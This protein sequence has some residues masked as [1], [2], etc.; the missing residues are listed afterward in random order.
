MRESHGDTAR[1]LSEVDVTVSVNI[2]D[3]GSSGL[4]NEERIETIV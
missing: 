4:F 3:R 2:H 1:P